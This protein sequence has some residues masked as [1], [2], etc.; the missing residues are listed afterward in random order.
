MTTAQALQIKA[1]LIEFAKKHGLWIEER[2]IRKPDLRDIILTISV[3][4][5]END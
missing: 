5:K 4:V 2:I 3:K 1:E